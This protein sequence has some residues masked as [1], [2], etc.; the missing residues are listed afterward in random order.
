MSGREL[1]RSNQT[2]NDTVARPL[3]ASRRGGHCALDCFP[4][5]PRL[6]R[7]RAE[8]KGK[9]AGPCIGKSLGAL[10]ADRIDALLS[11]ILPVG[12]GDSLSYPNFCFLVVSARARR[13]GVHE[14]KLR[15]ERGLAA[16]QLDIVGVLRFSGRSDLEPQKGR[17]PGSVIRQTTINDI[18]CRICMPR[19]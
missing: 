19:L 7:C 17:L 11:E 12:P 13:A 10:K 2:N 4:S 9:T 5:A 8:M 14:H 15:V 1:A 18:S 16:H 3:R 6:A